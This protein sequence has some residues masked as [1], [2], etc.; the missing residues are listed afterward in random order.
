[1]NDGWVQSVEEERDLG[2]IM[3]RGLKFSKQLPLTKN[4]ATLMLGIIKEEY[5]INLLK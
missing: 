1:M 3:S 5:R 4:K 2:V